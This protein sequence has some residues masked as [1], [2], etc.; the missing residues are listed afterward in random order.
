MLSVG[1]MYCIVS[2]LYLLFASKGAYN[3][4]IFFHFYW[5]ASRAG[6]QIFRN[7]GVFLRFWKNSKGFFTDFQTF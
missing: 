5:P 4:F 6:K 2:A 7:F 3:E 1:Y